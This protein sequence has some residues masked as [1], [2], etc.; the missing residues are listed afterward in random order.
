MTEIEELEHQLELSQAQEDLEAKLL[1]RDARIDRIIELLTSRIVNIED[2]GD[3]VSLPIAKLT[4]TDDLA[5][6]KRT[7]NEILRI[8]S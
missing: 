1:E 6:V 7:V 2:V 5:D 3:D 4:P 8:L